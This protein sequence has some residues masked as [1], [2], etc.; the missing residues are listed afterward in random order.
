[1]SV[2]DDILL[3]VRADLAARQD[4]VSLDELKAQAAQRQPCLNAV[5]VLKGDG[6]GVIA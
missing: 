5:A 1:M 2:L 6:V 4:L 3:G